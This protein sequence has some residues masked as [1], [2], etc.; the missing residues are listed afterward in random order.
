MVDRWPF[1]A[2]A[3]FPALPLSSLSVVFFLKAKLEALSSEHDSLRYCTL[4]DAGI[5][6]RILWIEFLHGHR[7]EL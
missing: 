6:D 3:R 7:Y 4:Y 1:H 2:D 5:A